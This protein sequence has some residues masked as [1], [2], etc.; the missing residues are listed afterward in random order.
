MSLRTEVMEDRY[1]TA[2]YLK[3]LRPLNEETPIYRYKYW[4]VVHNRFPHDKHHV[5]NDMLVLRRKCSSILKMRPWEWWEL[6]RIYREMSPKYD[7]IALNFPSM[8]S[9]PE[10]VHFHLYVFKDKY[11]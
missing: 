2:K 6:R 9:V 3:Q 4:V 8:I 5:T 10:F 11:K 1:R 7:K